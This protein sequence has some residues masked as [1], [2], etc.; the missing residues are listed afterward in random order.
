M[1]YGWRALA[2]CLAALFL[3]AG[4]CGG[5]TESSND[6]VSAIN[7]VQAKF[8]NDVKKVGAN[9]SGSTPAAAAKRT[10]S[11]LQA[12]IDK[13]VADL[14]AVKPPAKVKDLHSQLVSEMTQFESQVKAAGASLSAKDPKTIE[15]AQSKFAASASTLGS[16]IAQTIGAINKKLQA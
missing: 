9:Q 5:G 6:Y 15:T 1:S 7:K 2:T 16:R 14:K 13:A 4:G 11:N 3:V 8:A 12:A 10:F